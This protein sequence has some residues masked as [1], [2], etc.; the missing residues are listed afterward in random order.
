MACLDETECPSLLC[1]DGYCCDAACE[2]A[3]E[4]CNVEGAEGICTPHPSGT[5]PEGDCASG[6]CGE[7]AICAG[8][9]TWGISFG[10]VESNV[11]RASASDGSG[12]TLL[13]GDFSSP[14]SFGGSS[15]N[16]GGG[17]DFFV[18]KLGPGGSHVWSKR[19]GGVEDESL[20]GLAV[21]GDDNVIV[22]GQFE[23]SFTMGAFELTSAGGIDL[24]VAKLDP[25]GNTVWS[26]QHG[27]GE[28][29]RGCRDG[30][31]ARRGGT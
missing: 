15:L 26:G 17:S 1:V 28:A 9:V 5:D 12:N 23:G 21:D 11:V 7:G 14:I 8:D 30:V 18:V 2:A 24:F 3:C 22:A 20:R 25:Q 29:V 19:F 6:A 10:N 31:L 27:M 16:P 4:A 13:G